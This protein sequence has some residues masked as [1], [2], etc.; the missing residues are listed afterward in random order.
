[1]NAYASKLG[2][3]NTVFQNPHGLTHNQ[4]LANV[5]DL[6]VLSARAMKNKKF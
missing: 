1:M 4:N 2:M 3:N 6:A 5:G